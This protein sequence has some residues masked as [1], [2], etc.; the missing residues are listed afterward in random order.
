MAQI[1]LPV[2]KGYI[3]ASPMLIRMI[4]EEEKKQ[5]QENLTCFLLTYAQRLTAVP[6]TVI[7]NG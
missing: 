3:F 4:S 2:Y 6:V 1:S 5:M 7:Y